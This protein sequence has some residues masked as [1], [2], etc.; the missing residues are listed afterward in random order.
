VKPRPE[1]L[2]PIDLSP[3]Q[4]QEVE[5]KIAE[6][7]ADWSSI[8]SYVRGAAARA[9]ALP[10]YFDWTAFMALR[11]DGQVVWVPY[12]DEPGDTELV[13]EERI[14]NLGLFQGVK[15]LHPDLDFLEPVRPPDAIDCSGCRGTGKLSFGPG[16]EHLSHTVLCSC[17]G[18]GWLPRSAKR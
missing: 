6:F 17:G 4:R 10:L 13:Q 5:R 7:L 14:R 18:L 2:P 12:E 9:K 15:N 1:R 11:P 8:Y 16:Y 3:A